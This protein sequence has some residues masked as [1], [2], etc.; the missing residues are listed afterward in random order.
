LSE[1]IPTRSSAT[2]IVKAAPRVGQTHG[3]LVCCAG[4][5]PKGY[6]VRLYP[7]AFRTLADAQKFMRWD[8]IEYDWRLPK[9]DER[10]ESRRVEHRSLA[11]VGHV[12]DARA[13]ENLIAPLVVQSLNE[14]T[15]KGRS[16]AFIRPRDAK[17][18]IQRKL[19]AEYQAEKASFLQWHKQEAE[20]LFGYMSK[21]IVP[22][23]PSPYTFKYVYSIADGQREGTCQDWE[24][25]ATFLKWRRLYSEEKALVMM[26]GRFGDEYPQKG[27]VLAMGTHKAYKNW[28]I[29]GIVRLDHGAEDRLQGSL[30]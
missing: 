2:I 9:G 3:E 18:L 26:K 30:F 25:E 14:E 23:E 28:L 5:D 29:N 22:Y 8:I 21:S 1:I 15:Q 16:F 4:I 12:K 24:I 10:T 20:G 7:V 11:I 13:R 27:F 19:A 6:W 17:F